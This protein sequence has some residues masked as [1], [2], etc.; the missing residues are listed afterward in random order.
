MPKR[1]LNVK[2]IEYAANDVIYL[3]KIYEMMVEQI[4]EN[5]TQTITEVVESCEVYLKYPEINLDISYNM[6]EVDE[7]SQVQGL[8]K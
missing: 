7:S 1:P 2:M 4:K 8:I 5:K 6:R 3:P